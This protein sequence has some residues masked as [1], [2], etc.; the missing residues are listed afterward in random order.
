MPANAIFLDANILLE[1]VLGRKQATAAR[2]LLENQTEKPLISTLTAHLVVHF[3]QAIV[4]LPVLRQF[5]GD[6][7]LVSLES[8]DFDWAFMNM[9][10]SD[11]EDALQLAVAVRNGCSSIITFDKDL[12]KNY[13]DLAVID[14]QLLT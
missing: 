3:G 14:V 13:K 7:D 1:I 11:F 12:Y 10:G 6:Y 9:R 4:D 5:L 2:K 8:A